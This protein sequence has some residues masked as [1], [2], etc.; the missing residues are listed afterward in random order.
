VKTAKEIAEENGIV[1]STVR[2]RI[3]RLGLKP[4]AIKF[5]RR[6]YSEKKVR[7]IIGGEK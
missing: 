6:F 4:D 3:H 1:F 7:Q 2:V 5:G